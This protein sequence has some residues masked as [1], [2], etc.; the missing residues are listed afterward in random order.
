VAT[1]ADREYEF[2]QSQ[3]AVIRETAAKMRTAAVYKLLFG[4]ALLGIAALFFRQTWQISVVVG[5][6]GVKMLFLGASLYGAS[7]HF[8]RITETT[9]GDIGG[10]LTALKELRDVYSNQTMVSAAVG[11]ILVL[12]AFSLR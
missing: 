2:D 8:M 10:L 11:V 4:V 9:G 12:L 1:V 3:N 7:S 6:F 5:V